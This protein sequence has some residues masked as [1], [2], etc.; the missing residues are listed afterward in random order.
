[1][2]LLGQ[3]LR[4]SSFTLYFQG[5]TKYSDLKNVTFEKV[6]LAPSEAGG[7]FSKRIKL[8]KIQNL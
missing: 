6:P 3:F 7:F 5:K 1:V 8:V 2:D 4:Y